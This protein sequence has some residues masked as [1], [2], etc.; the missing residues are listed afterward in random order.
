MFK[1][2]SSREVWV[3]VSEAIGQSSVETVVRETAVCCSMAAEILA[4]KQPQTDRMR[5][6]AAAYRLLSKRLREAERE[7]AETLEQIAEEEKKN[8]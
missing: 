6:E 1:K 5:A 7:Y 4:G 3:K 8:G 2:I